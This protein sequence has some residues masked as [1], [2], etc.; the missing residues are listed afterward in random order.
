MTASACKFEDASALIEKVWTSAQRALDGAEAEGPPS[1]VG[2]DEDPSRMHVDIIEYGTARIVV[3]LWMS[4][5]MY[6]HLRVWV[7]G[8]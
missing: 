7:P 3:A 5:A 2:A 1:V 8:R 6:D 4:A